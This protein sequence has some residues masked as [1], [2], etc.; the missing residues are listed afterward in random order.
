M[1]GVRWSEAAGSKRYCAVPIV[2]TSHEGSLQ[3]SRAWRAAAAVH[4][5]WGLYRASHASHGTLS[6]CLAASSSPHHPIHRHQ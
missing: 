2:R 4:L 3:G 1:F 5:N 6:L